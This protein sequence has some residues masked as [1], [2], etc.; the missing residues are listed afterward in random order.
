MTTEQIYTKIVRHERKLGQELDEKVMDIIEAAI[1]KRKSPLTV[2]QVDAEN[3]PTEIAG[4]VMELNNEVNIFKRL[5]YGTSTPMNMLL[6]GATAKKKWALAVIR[7][8]PNRRNVC[9]EYEVLISKNYLHNTSL[10]KGD[11]ILGIATPLKHPK[12]LAWEL[13]KHDIY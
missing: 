6:L 3:T 9:S 7:T 13:I 5:G 1:G 10:A 11:F 2:E 12:G 8:K 4:K